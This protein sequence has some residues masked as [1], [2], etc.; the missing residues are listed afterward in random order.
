MKFMYTGTQ[1]AHERAGEG[2]PVSQVQGN[3]RQ[4]RT[5]DSKAENST[6][7]SI[8]GAKCVPFHALVCFRSSRS[9]QFVEIIG[10]DGDREIQ[11]DNQTEIAS[12]T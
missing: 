12:Y 6:L 10:Y 4:A 1:G 11:Y 9:E 2:L 7:L 3:V 5:Q 8:S